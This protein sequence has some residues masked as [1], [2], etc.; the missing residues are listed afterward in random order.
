MLADAVISS[1]CTN[2][3]RFVDALKRTK[4]GAQ[5]VRLIDVAT[6]NDS[7]R[8]GLTAVPTLVLRDGR[9]LV[10]TDAFQWL[11]QFA[12]EVEPDAFG[13][14]GALPFSDITADIGFATFNDPYTSIE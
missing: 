1:E 7:Q 10:G 4:T 11:D 13:G 12:D 14:F 2:C 3:A 9:R 6:L 5:Q 8:A